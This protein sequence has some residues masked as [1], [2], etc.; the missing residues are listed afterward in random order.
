MLTSLE[1]LNLTQIPSESDI[2]GW[3]SHQRSKSKCVDGKLA[4]LDLGTEV[5]V[6]IH[7][8]ESS[9][10]DSESGDTKTVIE[11][12]AI[13][14]KK[15]VSYGK[16][17]NDAERQE[18]DEANLGEVSC[19]NRKGRQTPEDPEVLLHDEFIEWVKQGLHAIGYQ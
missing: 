9:V 5:E 12:Y 8:K 4:I 16:F 2:Q 3:D 7:P 10:V 13:R 18:Y 14:S 6:Y 19:I 11:A 1:Q 17:I 15:P